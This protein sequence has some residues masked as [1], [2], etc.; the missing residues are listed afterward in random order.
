M[1]YLSVQDHLLPSKPQLNKNSKKRILWIVLVFIHFLYLK[2][3]FSKQEYIN[4]FILCIFQ[5]L[6]ILKYSVFILCRMFQTWISANRKWDTGIGRRILRSAHAADNILHAADG[7]P[8]FQKGFRW[9]SRLGSGPAAA[10]QLQS[11]LL[12]CFRCW[13]LLLA[14][15]CSGWC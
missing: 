3:A 4:I 9:T 6:F 11:L 15:R 14:G 10:R 2:F 1:F 12:S 8:V 13:L 5:Y 7:R